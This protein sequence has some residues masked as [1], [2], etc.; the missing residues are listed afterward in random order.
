MPSKVTVI[1]VGPRDGLQNES[2]FLSVEQRVGMI[3]DLNVAGLKRIEIGAFVSPKWVPQMRDTA[4]VIAGL[5]RMG[6]LRPEYSVLV[7]NEIG[8]EAALKSGIKEIAVFA[9][10]SES[11][12]K[13]NI[14]CTIA[15]SFERFK[16]VIALAKKNRIRVRGYLSTAI[17]CPYDGATPPARVV[18]LTQD[19]IKLGVYEVSVGDTI[20]VATPQQVQRLL[21]LYK[22]K[23]VSFS[24]LAMHFHNTRGTALANVFKSLEMGVRKFDSSIGG[25]GGCPYAAGAT[26]NLATEDLVYMLHGL[27]HQTGVNLEKMIEVRLGLE[28]LMQKPLPAQVTMAK[29]F[30]LFKV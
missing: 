19:M 26:G 29:S 28:R 6:G 7:P 4:E 1:E 12:S 21:S 25:L 13:K 5:K 16:P 11:F 27:G 9:A 18:K 24:K 17:A 3:R 2:M 23:K 20:G 22:R 15:E 30:G 10:C 14:N 8:M